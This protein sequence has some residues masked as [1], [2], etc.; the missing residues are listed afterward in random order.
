MRRRRYGTG[1]LCLILTM[2]ALGGCG[3]FPAEEEDRR[4]QMAESAEQIEY[5]VEAVQVEDLQKTE[6][7]TVVY[8]QT[9]DESLS[10]DADGEYI[11]HVYVSVGDEVSEGDVL[12]QLDVGD[13]PDKLEQLNYQI[14][15][16]EKAKAD[17]IELKA[18][19]LHME[20]L[21]Y[22]AGWYAD[23]AEYAE[24]AA[25][26]EANYSDTLQ[27]YDDTLYI[28]YMQRDVYNQMIADSYLYA[29]M[30]GVVSYV[31]DRLEGSETQAGKEIIKIIDDTE[32]YFAS[33]T[34]YASSFTDGD[35]LEITCGDHTYET[36]VSH[37]EDGLN[38]YFT[39]TMP[40][41]TIT[42]GAYGSYELILQESRGA[43]TVNYN[44]VHK[45]GESY[46]V[47]QLD[48]DGIRKT[49]EVTVGMN[50]GG[51]IEILSGLSEGDIIVAE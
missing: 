1:I 19:D 2:A 23:D 18:Y 38:V 15:L 36:V 34:K 10:F 47:Y 4:V 33:D 49:T 27:K 40:D 39:L 28:Q 8:Q 11:A 35:V 7:I 13:V 20:L 30:S 48:E 43:L 44:Y 17:Q 50:A 32:C 42:L 6:K 41:T 25:K 21:R 5:E 24:A 9:K 14:S 31:A 16:N 3:I 12:A 37:S 51:R 26:V 46:Y 29:G 45:S 22:Q